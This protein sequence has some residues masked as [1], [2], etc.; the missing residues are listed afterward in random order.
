MWVEIRI[1]TLKAFHN[2]SPGLALKPWGYWL[3]L[4]GCYSEGVATVLPLANDNA[5]LSELRRRE[6]CDQRSQGSE[7]QP[8]A[9]ISERFQR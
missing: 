7:A 5:T 6:K 8:W 1:L 4:F 9:G 3:R 2:S